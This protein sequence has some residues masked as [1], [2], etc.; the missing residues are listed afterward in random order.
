MKS[1][2]SDSK[3]WQALCLAFLLYDFHMK[4]TVLAN[5]TESAIDI[6]I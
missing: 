5:Y 2:I 1:S 4:F 6:G 3:P